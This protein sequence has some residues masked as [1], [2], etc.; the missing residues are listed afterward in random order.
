MKCQVLRF[1]NNSVALIDALE[2]FSNNYLCCCLLD[3]AGK[4]TDEILIFKFDNNN[5][6][7]VDDKKELAELSELFYTRLAD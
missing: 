7:I 3:N 4:P 1:N 2:Y 5:L 6:I